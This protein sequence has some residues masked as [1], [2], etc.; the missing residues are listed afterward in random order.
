[1][2]KGVEDTA[3]YLFNRLVSLNE[4]GSHPDKFGSTSQELH[5]FLQKRA[6]SQRGSL[7]PLS[8]HDTKRSADVRARISVLSEI[9]EEWGRRL[10]VWRELNRSLKDG[11]GRGGIGPG[12]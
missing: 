3:L 6:S 11:D 8:T 9:P 4:V 10:K 12:R 2:A 7:S 5:A 1:M